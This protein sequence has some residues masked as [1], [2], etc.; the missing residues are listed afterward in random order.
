M[1]TRGSVKASTFPQSP[2]LWRGWRVASADGCWAAALPGDSAAQQRDAQPE[3]IDQMHPLL[4]L[5]VRGAPLRVAR[6]EEDLHR[7]HLK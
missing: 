6:S 3:L 7:A 4:H 5:S 2:L 1:K